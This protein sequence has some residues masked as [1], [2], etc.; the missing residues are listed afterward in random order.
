MTDWNTWQQL[1]RYVLAMAGTY[2]SATGAP[3]DLVQPAV[4]GAMALVAL[5]WWFFWNRTRPAAEPAPTP[6]V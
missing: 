6:V 4:G 2:V 5:G 1:V 3:D